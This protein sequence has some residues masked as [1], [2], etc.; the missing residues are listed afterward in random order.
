MALVFGPGELSVVDLKEI[1]DSTAITATAGS[2]MCFFFIGF[3]F[4]PGK[5]GSF[6]AAATCH[7]GIFLGKFSFTIFK[8]IRNNRSVPARVGNFHSVVLA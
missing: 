1:S 5:V 8:I 3:A 6:A 7:F 2:I 4:D